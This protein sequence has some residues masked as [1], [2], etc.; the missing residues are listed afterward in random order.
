MPAIDKTPDEV[1]VF[2]QDGINFLVNSFSKED[3][4]SISR[5]NI[6]ER[7]VEGYYFAVDTNAD[8]DIRSA[9]IIAMSSSRFLIEQFGKETLDMVA[10]MTADKLF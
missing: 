6:E 9:I 5:N 3:K 2:L 10:F 8:L 1:K 7:M 4:K